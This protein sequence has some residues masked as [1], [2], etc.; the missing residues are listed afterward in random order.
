MALRYSLNEIDISDRIDI[1][2]K[3]FIEAGNRTIDI[4]TIGDH[5]M[6]SDVA[7]KI[8]EILKDE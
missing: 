3:R 6:T 5:L 2:I 8:I 4:K 1:A 7:K